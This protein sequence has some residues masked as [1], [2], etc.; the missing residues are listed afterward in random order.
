ME[1]SM[2]L[3][4]NNCPRR[5]ITLEKKEQG[6][7]NTLKRSNSVTVFSGFAIMIFVAVLF[8]TNHRNGILSGKT[9]PVYYSCQHSH[10]E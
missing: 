4:K 2:K 3:S 5:H 8:A 7:N 1:K 9:L 10:V 6:K